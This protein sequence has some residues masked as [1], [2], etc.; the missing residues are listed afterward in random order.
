MSALL[1][2]LMGLAIIAVLL[3]L[4]GGLVV[5]ARGRPADARLSNRLMRWRVMMQGA[6]VLLFALAMMISRN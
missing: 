5:M 3:S 6:A 1:T 4:A 2:I